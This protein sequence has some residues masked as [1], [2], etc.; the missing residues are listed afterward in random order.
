MSKHI[1]ISV[2]T[3][4]LTAVSC[5]QPI[6]QNT[7]DTSGAARTIANNSDELFATVG[8]IFRK[9]ADDVKLHRVFDENGAF[10]VKGYHEFLSARR[11]EYRA[12]GLTDEADKLFRNRLDHHHA[13]NDDLFKLLR[14]ASDDV[15]EQFRR[16]NPRESAEAF[17]K[18][19]KYN[20]PFKPIYIFQRLKKSFDGSVVFD[21]KTA[22]KNWKIKHIV[23]GVPV[24]EVLFD[25]D[26]ITRMYK[27]YLDDLKIV[28]HDA[29]IK[30][31]TKYKNL[32][33]VPVE[34]I[35]AETDK[36]VVS[37]FS[38]G[39]PKSKYAAEHG[40]R[41][42]H[43]QVISGAYPE[44]TAD[45][46]RAYMTGELYVSGATGKQLGSQDKTLLTV[47]DMMDI[48][49]NKKAP[50]VNFTAKNNKSGHFPIDDLYS[51]VNC[52]RVFAHVASFMAMGVNIPFYV[53]KS[54]SGQETKMNVS[55]VLKKCRKQVGR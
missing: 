1:I 22:I 32:R 34:M 42:Q 10:N 11:D 7:S 35:Y 15:A 33:D 41:A 8:K 46:L 12:L 6:N 55:S 3:F 23:N 13:E 9:Y 45:K 29:Y 21:M 30:H 20:V 18:V 54:H 36:G 53:F 5:S 2:L 24:E 49:Q 39:I 19:A 47:G 51:G 28:D 16:L 48:A 31:T 27:E 43:P 38:L 17:W 26:V 44:L 37:A 50:Y 52:S 14:P 40:L 4:A 25:E